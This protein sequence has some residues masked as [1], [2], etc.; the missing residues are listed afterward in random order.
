[1]HSCT[2][3]RTVNLKGKAACCG[4]G[5]CQPRLQ[6]GGGCC[7]TRAPEPRTTPAPA[8]ACSRWRAWSTAPSRRSA[9]PCPPAPRCWCT[10]LRSA[11]ACCCSR[12][13]TSRCWAAVWSGWSRRGCAWWST[14]TGRQVSVVGCQR[15]RARPRRVGTESI[16][17]GQCH[18]MDA[19]SMCGLW[20]GFCL[21][22][23]IRPLPPLQLAGAAHQCSWPRPC[24][25][26]L[27]Q[28]GR[29][30]RPMVASSSNRSTRHSSSHSSNTSTS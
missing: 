23:F 28:H 18:V 17:G 3:R 30:S 7:C 13:P 19:L 16:F 22:T 12:P 24:S 11:V 6:R 8:Q 5:Y 25:W 2:V 26:L 20:L 29:A 27:P 4:A 15:G 21:T 10:T 14:G 9:P 1:M